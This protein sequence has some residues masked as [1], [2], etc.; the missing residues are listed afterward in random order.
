MTGRTR[1]VQHD[2]ETNSAR[3]V[4]CGPRRLAP[5]GLQTEQACIK[6]MLEGD[7]LNPVIVPGRHQKKDGS[8]HFCVD[9]LTV[10]DAYPF[11]VLMIQFVSWVINSGSQQWQVAMSTD[12]NERQHL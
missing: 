10:K 3:P 11:L 12:A 7:R 1:A 6:E 8:T 5:T 4:R 2:I 9:S